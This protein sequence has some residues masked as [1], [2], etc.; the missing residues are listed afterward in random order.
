MI[1]Y[2]SRGQNYGSLRQERAFHGNAFF[3]F[4]LENDRGL[5]ENDTPETHISHMVAKSVR[6]LKNLPIGHVTNL[7]KRQGTA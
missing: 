7:G 6:N 1:M 2:V 5:P 4:S 3:S